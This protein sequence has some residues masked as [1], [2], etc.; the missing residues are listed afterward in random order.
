MDG[1]FDE[2]PGGFE[3][4][5]QEIV[6]RVVAT[7]RGLSDAQ[8]KTKVYLSAPMRAILRAERTSLINLYNAPISFTSLR[9]A[10]EGDEVVT[11]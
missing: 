3:A 6:D 5:L 4:E 10:P 1:L 11:A 9:H 2:A 7:A 8:L